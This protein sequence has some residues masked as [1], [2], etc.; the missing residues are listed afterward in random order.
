MRDSRLKKLM[1]IKPFVSGSLGKTYRKC[2]KKNCKC[3]RGKLHP[4][5]QL[6]YKKKGKTETIYIPVDL[7]KEVKEWIAEYKRI[8]KLMEEISNLQK[9]IIRRHSKEKKAK[10]KK[11]KKSKSG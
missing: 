11:S 6:T 5:Y 8:K 10:G 3:A 7:H 1:K 9:L 4:G 2:G